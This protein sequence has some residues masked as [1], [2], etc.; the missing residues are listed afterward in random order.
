MVKFE[1]TGN[2]TIEHRKN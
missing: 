1:I 2:L